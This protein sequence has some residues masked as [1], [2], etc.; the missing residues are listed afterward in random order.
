MKQ[1]SENFTAKG[2]GGKGKKG[3][4]WSGKGKRN[5]ANFPG[6][7]PTWPQFDTHTEQHHGYPNTHRQLD[8]HAPPFN[9]LVHPADDFQDG[10]TRPNTQEQ[11]LLFERPS[12]NGWDAP[13]PSYPKPSYEQMLKT[14]LSH[15]ATPFYPS[16][17]VEETVLPRFMQEELEQCNIVQEAED[18]EALG[19]V[20]KCLDNIFE[21]E[22]EE[23]VNTPALSSATSLSTAIT[24]ELLSATNTPNFPF[25]NAMTLTTGHAAAAVAGNGREESSYTA[26]SSSSSSSAIGNNTFNSLPPNGMPNVMRFYEKWGTTARPVGRP[27]GG[28]AGEWGNSSPQTALQ[29]HGAMDAAGGGNAFASVLLNGIQLIKVPLPPPNTEASLHSAS[30]NINIT[31]EQ[32]G[33]G[34]DI[35]FLTS[36]DSSR[37]F[38]FRASIECHFDDGNSKVYFIG[39][40]R[41]ADVPC[42]L[43]RYIK[44]NVT[45]FSVYV[46]HVPTDTPRRA[47]QEPDLLELL[48]GILTNPQY[49]KDGGSISSVQIYNIIKESPLYGKVIR[50]WYGGSWMAFI[51]SSKEFTVF[52]Y[53]EE[54]VKRWELGPRYKRG[55]PRICLSSTPLA[56]V[57]ASDRM[58]C[59]RYNCGNEQI[60]TTLVESLKANGPSSQRDIL[61]RLRH[62]SCFTDRLYPTRSLLERFVSQHRSSFE[63]RFGREQPLRVGLKRTPIETDFLTDPEGG[64]DVWGKKVTSEADGTPR[65][66]DKAF[67]STFAFEA[68][69]GGPMQGEE[70]DSPVRGVGLLGPF[71]SEGRMRVGE[72]TSDEERNTLLQHCAEEESAPHHHDEMQM[73]FNF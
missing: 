30:Q 66:D 47:P 33:L 39:S 35:Y 50:D 65:E 55:E 59:Y 34:M 5:T 41:K 62:C 20:N 46:N 19:K 52:A 48:E 17:D 54:E 13:S 57:Q 9:P 22:D 27:L 49:N 37:G 70:E 25:Q 31:G 68:A 26:S 21:D 8:A 1:F 44:G 29:T 23:K 6:R 12:K 10:W 45:S 51:K 53:S 32:G 64:G 7:S 42:L 58:S 60:L 56:H 61:N 38:E 69:L 43:G 73:T 15:H 36:I 18:C 71:L 16:E 14:N 4:M 72:E 11:T 2:K 40:T 28:I 67:G 63:L 24:P 3:A